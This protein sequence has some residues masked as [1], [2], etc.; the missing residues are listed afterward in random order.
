[1]SAPAPSTELS[2][3]SRSAAAARSAD[4][5]PKGPELSPLAPA[6]LFAVRATALACVAHVGR[7][8]P[9]AADGAACEGMRRALGHAP[10]KGRVV[11]GEGEKDGAP[12]LSPGELVG[13]GDGPQFD[14][15]VDP[16]EG[17]KACAAGL[18]GALSTIAIGARGTLDALPACSWYLDKLLVSARGRGAVDIARPATENVVSLAAR[19]EKPISELGVVVLDKPRHQQLIEILRRLGARVHCPRDGD[20]AASVLVLLEAGALD[21][22]IGV[23]GTPEGVLSACATVALG[24]ELQARLAPQ[25]E[26][27][28]RRL[29]ELG[30]DLERV[31]TEAELAPSDALFAACGITTGELLA[32]PAVCNGQIATDSLLL[33]R[34]GA[35]RVRTTTTTAAG[36]GVRRDSPASTGGGR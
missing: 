6:A 2:D 25:R 27:E 13:A 34:G 29:T 22:L 8:D 26:S 10:G 23:G 5:E 31:Y 3:H 1:V 36:A 28:T 9:L 21:M 24:G 15:A 14:L 19:L 32:A 30:V 7:G 33:T 18:P 20:V 12:M 11:V 17:T 4:G 16:L 35:S